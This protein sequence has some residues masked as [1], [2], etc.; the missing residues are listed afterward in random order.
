M[1]ELPRVAAERYATAHG[2]VFMLYDSMLL[3][4]IA[5]L[6]VAISCVLFYFSFTIKNN[7]LVV[8]I[9]VLAFIPCTVLI[10]RIDDVPYFLL[11]L[12]LILILV[13]STKVRQIRTTILVLGIFFFLD[14]INMVESTSRIS[15]GQPIECGDRSIVCVVDTLVRTYD[16]ISVSE[17][18]RFV[19]FRPYFSLESDDITNYHF[20]KKFYTRY[21]ISEFDSTSAIKRLYRY[22]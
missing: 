1:R 17:E 6:G 3:H 22:P 21:W 20:L 5:E 15:H 16:K 11:G 19:Y 4:N 9:R 2:Q 14:G 13:F 18:R 12:F 7:L 10:I 8:L